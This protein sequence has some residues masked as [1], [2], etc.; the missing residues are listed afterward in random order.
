MR[1][2]YPYPAGWK[3]SEKLAAVIRVE[4]SMKVLESFLLESVR[5]AC[6][7]P[8]A[9]KG[10]MLSI[11]FLPWIPNADFLLFPCQNRTSN[12]FVNEFLKF[13][14]GFLKIQTILLSFLSSVNSV[15]EVHVRVAHNG[16]R[17]TLTNSFLLWTRKL[18]VFLLAYEEPKNVPCCQGN[19]YSLGSCN[20]KEARAIFIGSSLFFF[21]YHRII[22]R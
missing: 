1:S 21:F 2:A 20:R 15:T 11:V 16:E 22:E 17:E 7:Y 8:T 3:L 6:W 12:S 5:R 14:Q 4:T 9:T 19:S 10:F 18:A 13:Q